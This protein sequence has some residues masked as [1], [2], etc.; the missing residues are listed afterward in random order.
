M[1]KINSAGKKENVLL[2]RCHRLTE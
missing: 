1:N 2:W